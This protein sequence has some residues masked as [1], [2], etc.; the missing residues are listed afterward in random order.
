MTL[1]S[2]PALFLDRDGVINI[3][4]AYVSKPEHFEFVDGIF[5]LCRTAKRLGYLV[6][7]VT[8][9]AGIGRGYY[10]EQ[11]FLNLTEWMCGVFNAQGVVIDRVYFCPS[12]PEYGIGKYKVDSPFRKPGPGMILQAAEEFDV[13]LARSV[14]VGDK[15]TDIQAGIAAGVKCNLLYFPSYPEEPIE[16][17]ASAV[18][19]R[20]ADVSK[21]LES[22]HNQ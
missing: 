17:A 9:Q 11:D 1:S 15:E 20:L 6:F 13:D 19:S 10:T 7:V 12:H 8:N 4:H 5:E 16:T 2:R 14:V 3:D 18:V 21:F 22:V